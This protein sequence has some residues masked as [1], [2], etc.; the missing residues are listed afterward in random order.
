MSKAKMVNMSRTEIL[1]RFLIIDL[2][3]HEILNKMNIKECMFRRYLKTG[4]I[5][6]NSLE[7]LNVLSIIYDKRTNMEVK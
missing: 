7:I 2:S 5:S 1:K 4:R 3:K 6:E